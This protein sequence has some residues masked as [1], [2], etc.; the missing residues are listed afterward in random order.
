[1]RGFLE[2]NE[3]LIRTVFRIVVLVLLV[4]TYRMAR[5]A[6]NS[7]EY[8]RQQATATEEAVQDVAEKVARLRR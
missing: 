8:A 1:M 6:M 3:A 5:D 7:A 4:L 2:R